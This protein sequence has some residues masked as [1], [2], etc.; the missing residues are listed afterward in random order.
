MV[1]ATTEVMIIEAATVVATVA[2]EAVT[3]MVT[4][5]VTAVMNVVVIVVN[6]ALL[7]R[8]SSSLK[9]DNNSI[10]NRIWQVPDLT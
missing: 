3:I 9:M 10:H 7:K 6:L 8:D 1:E 5:E 2:T 4:V